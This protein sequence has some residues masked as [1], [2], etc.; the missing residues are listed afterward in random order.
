LS[1]DE[2]FETLAPPIGVDVSEFLRGLEVELND[3]NFDPM[4]DEVREIV[5][6]DGWSVRSGVWR[7]AGG[8]PHPLILHI[9]G[10]G[11]VSGN[12]VSH[13]VFDSMLA[14]R[15]FVVA[16]L[17][18]RRAP[19]HRFPAALDDCK[20]AFEW[21][22][23]N[24]HEVGADDGRIAMVGDSAGASLAA[25]VLASGS[26][27]CSAAALLF[28]IYDYHR[29]LPVLE[30]I[31]GGVDADTQA[32]LPQGSFE[33]LRGDPR[34]SPQFAAIGWPPLYVATGTKDPLLSESR[35]FHDYL[36]A[37]GVDHSYHELMGAPHSYVQLTKH[38]EHAVGM[39]SLVAFLTR[40]LM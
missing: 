38:P 32:Y 34:V 11:W 30:P 13:R 5:V 28:G 21:F 17:D 27:G 3:V 19:K 36:T 23:D 18:Y 9:H 24:A 6:R 4:P 10:G 1:Y 35:S 16:S 39:D 25:S 37:L 40:H 29:A 14:S 7:P 15:G 22:R 31:V 26:S 12:H 20:Y 33:A 2:Y 8:G